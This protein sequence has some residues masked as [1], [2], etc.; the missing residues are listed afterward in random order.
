[1]YK[2][3]FA[4]LTTPIH[5]S[6][7]ARR[8]LSNL[9]T[10]TKYKFPYIEVSISHVNFVN[11]PCENSETGMESETIYTVFKMRMQYYFITDYNQQ[12]QAISKNRSN[13]FYFSPDILASRFINSACCARYSSL[14]IQSGI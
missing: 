9:L 12:G 7:R 6:L 11:L 14:R 2:N 4:K 13:T 1:M 10:I 3:I 5:T 8:R